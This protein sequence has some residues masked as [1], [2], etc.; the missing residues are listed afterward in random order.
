MSASEVAI[1]ICISVLVGAAPILL[2]CVGEIF[3]QRAG[4]MNLG[5]EGIM[6]MGAVVGYY[7]GYKTDSAGSAIC[8]VMAVGALVGLGYAFLTV[9]LRADQVVSGLALVTFGTGMSGFVGKGVV[10]VASPVQIQTLPIPLLC[11][12]PLL[13]PVLFNRDPLI[14]ALY[15]LVPAATIFMLKTKPGL[16]LRALG[17]DPGVLD[18]DGYNVIRQRYFYVTFGCVLSALGGAYLSL[19]STPFWNDGM[20]SGKGWIAAALVIFSMWNPVIA[21]GGALLFSGVNVMTN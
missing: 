15:L 9:T 3:S 18:A 19:V 7:T 1:S 14:Y 4:I 11:D 21:I 13:G 8:A 10:S 17:E 5:L 12:I 16:L 20:T 2:A 6:L